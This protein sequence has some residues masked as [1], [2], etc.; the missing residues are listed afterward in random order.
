MR[1][2]TGVASL[3]RPASRFG[4]GQ[5][6][7]CR[8]RLR[9][10]PAAPPARLLAT[11]CFTLAA[12][13]VPAPHAGLVPYD[14]VVELWSDGTRKRRWIALPDG[15]GM[16][17]SPTGAW[18]APPGTFIVKEFALEDTPNHRRAIETR[19]LARTAS[20]WLGFSYRW[21]PDGSDA[22]LLT[23]GTFTTD[24]PLATG[25]THTHVYPS[26]S[27]CLSC[28]EASYGPLLGLR[29][30]Q[31]ARWFDYG[32]TIADQLPTLVHL[33]VGPASTAAPFIAAHDPSATAEQRARSYMAANCAHCHNPQ[34]IAVKDLRYTTP[35][36]ATNL[37]TSIVPGSPPQSVV[38]ARVT[39]RP[40]MPPL[41]TLVPDPLAADLFGRWISGMSTCP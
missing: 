16:T 32:G 10:Q 12:P 25:G 5:L 8:C 11:G 15:A 19:V 6:R 38:Y 18:A 13:A 29:P 23:D 31:L 4:V 14:I 24:W 20:G 21:R 40:G 2:H 39:Q 36:A 22:D 34:H 9:V 26:R 30:Q 28:H 1:R 3:Q 33:G 41:A 35:L 27:Q 7:A 17:A 37:C